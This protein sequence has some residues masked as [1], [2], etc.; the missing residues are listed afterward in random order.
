MRT[1]VPN[2][3]PL[4][5]L[6]NRLDITVVPF[7]D[8]GSRVLVL[9]ERQE[10]RLLIHL[11]ERW[12]KLAQVEGHY[13]V[14]PPLVSGLQ[15]LDGGGAP[16]SWDL[17]TYPH[18]LE[19][20]TPMG[21]FEMAFDGPELLVLRPPPGRCGVRFWVRAERAAADRRG[22]TTRGVR[23]LAYTTNARICSN[24]VQPEGP[25]RWRVELV[26]EATPQTQITLNITPRLGFDRR[27][28][29]YDPVAGSERRWREWFQAVPEVDPRFRPTY[30]YAWYLLRAGLLNTRY[31][32]TREALIPSKVHYVGLWQW[33]AFFHALAYRHVDPLL[34]TDQFR[35][36]FDHQRPDGRLPDCVFDEGTVEYL[37]EPTPGPVTKPPV[38]GWALWKVYETIQDADFVAELYEP[39][40]R[41]QRWWTEQCDTDGDGLPE[42]HHPFSSGL[43]DSP[44]WDLGMP[45]VSPDLPTYLCLQAE[46]LGRMARLLG[47]EKEAERWEA[48]A[49]ELVHRM[50]ERLYDPETG[51]FWAYRI[52][53]RGS[54]RVPVL[55]PLSLLPLWT[56]RLVEEAVERLVGYLLDPQHF[57]TRYPVPSVARSDPRYRPDRMWRGP[58]WIN[59]NYMLIEGL[60]RCGR[61]TVARE[62]CERTLELVALHSDIK[63]YYH[64]ETGAVPAG[65]APGFG[66]SAALYA[67]LAIRRSRGEI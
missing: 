51:L 37:E 40:S 3:D 13:R 43:D 64:P 4:E 61:Y 30:D 60:L 58:T 55:T 19:F 36:L 26:V 27:I 29:P 6:C 12:P 11:C 42:Y 32:L 33:D 1:A 50:V 18:K 38:A 15:F 17:I 52:T 63:E 62:L 65:A 35:V 24:E 57:W 23:H 10:H 39:L 21:P 44:L 56:G 53:E 49:D 2:P 28:R 9:R 25:N 8:R 41:W 46:A 54:E 34:A 22:G 66:W 31:Y 16:L 14:R 45:V 67:D 7:T 20:H 5:L 47:E 48:E 59:L